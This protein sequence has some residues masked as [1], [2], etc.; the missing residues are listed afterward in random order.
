[1]KKNLL[2]TSA[3]VAALVA[4]IVCTSLFLP[5]HPTG[6]AIPLSSVRAALDSSASSVG[7]QLVVE[8]AVSRRFRNRGA[9]GLQTWVRKV[10]GL[11]DPYDATS[12]VITSGSDSV[13][14]TGLH[15]A[16]IV[17]ELRIDPPYRSSKLSSDLVREFQKVL[18]GTKF[19]H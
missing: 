10:A 15:A 13:T 7:G 4:I 6:K 11:N 17:T 3:V 16:G 12:Y 8:R 5:H 14:V 19:T 9:F 1:M 18:P 2:A